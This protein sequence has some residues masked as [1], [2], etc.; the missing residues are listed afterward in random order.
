MVRQL[1]VSNKHLVV[2]IELEDSGHIYSKHKYLSSIFEK[3]TLMEFVL[4]ISNK[5]CSNKYWK[6]DMEQ[7]QKH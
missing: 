7:T 3:Q 2:N 1:N 6:K 5:L 4:C